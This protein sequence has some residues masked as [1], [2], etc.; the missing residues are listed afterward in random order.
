MPCDESSTHYVR[1]V[2]LGEYGSTSIY[3]FTYDIRHTQYDV[4]VAGHKEHDEKTL[5]L[6]RPVTHAVTVQQGLMSG[7]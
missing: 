2:R 3:F 5:A 7:R 1:Y 4:T 6:H